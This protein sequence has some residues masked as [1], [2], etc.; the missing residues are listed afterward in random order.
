MSNSLTLAACN[1][2]KTST[3]DP[4]PGA[5]PSAGAV[6]ENQKFCVYNQTCECFLSLGVTVAD[7]VLGLFADSPEPRSPGHNEGF[8]FV[9]PGELNELS[10]GKD[11]PF[12]WVYLDEHH[13]VVHLMESS[14]KAPIALLKANAVSVLAL[15][16][17]TV[18]SSQTSRG[19]QLVICVA[20]ALEFR[21][22]FAT[23]AESLTG[24]R[25][26][27]T[28]KAAELLS[29]DAKV[30]ELG[31]DRRRESREPWPNL[32]AYDR[33][34][35]HLAIH[36]IRDSSATGL[37]L[38][39]ENRWPLGTLVMMTLQRTD[40]ADE[41]VDRSIAVHLKV[42][43]WGPDGVGLQFVLPGGAQDSPAT[44]R[45]I[46]GPV[47]RAGGSKRGR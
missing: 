37:Y 36:G 21:L 44:A 19:N 28:E 24:A 9:C 46:P 26:T 33:N 40:L 20:E 42:I 39:T 7:S 35:V 6:V 8:W 2:L 13:R 10:V 29:V 16:A 1:E 18:Y 27:G 3:A 47:P 25:Q 30:V 4:R 11:M 12:D 5:N 31:G 17:H 32:I 41:S 34:G 22:K 15:P 43:R 23:A 14:P 38:L 45:Q